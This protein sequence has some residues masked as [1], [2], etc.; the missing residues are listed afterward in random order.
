MVLNKTFSS[1]KTFLVILTY[2]ILFNF[3]IPKAEDRFFYQLGASYVEGNSHSNFTPNGTGIPFAG[4]IEGHRLD[5]GIGD[6][7]I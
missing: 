3:L 7:F 6:G 4:N 5:F 2:L 1:K